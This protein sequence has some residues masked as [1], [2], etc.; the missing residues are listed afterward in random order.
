MFPKLRQN[1]SN[2]SEIATAIILSIVHDTTV[3]Y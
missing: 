1:D 3:I 2:V